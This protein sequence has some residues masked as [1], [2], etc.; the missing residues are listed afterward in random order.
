MCLCILSSSVTLTRTNYQASSQ[1]RM[2]EI[3][4]L[5]REDIASRTKKRKQDN[6]LMETQKVASFLGY[7]SAYLH[8]A[9]YFTIISLII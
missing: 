6:I 3:K 7:H 9:L 2:E 1:S 5:R 4:M 8:L